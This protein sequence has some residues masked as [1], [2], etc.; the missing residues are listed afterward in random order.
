MKLCRSEIYLNFRWND[1]SWRQQN[2]LNL[3]PSHQRNWLKMNSCFDQA[4]FEPTR[5]C[6]QRVV[7]PASCFLLCGNTSSFRRHL[8]CKQAG[9]SS[10]YLTGRCPDMQIGG[11]QP[12]P[13]NRVQLC[14]HLK[15]KTNVKYCLIHLLKVS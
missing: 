9:H 12:Y 13:L 2:H 3:N 15:V 7:Q 1:P 8:A 4:G 10:S 11:P 5:S 14:I 6:S